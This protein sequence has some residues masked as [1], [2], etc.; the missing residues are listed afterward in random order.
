M[1]GCFRGLLADSGLVFNL[2]SA[3][4]IAAGVQ[5]P[6]EDPA[7]IEVV[8]WVRVL[9][10]LK[11]GQNTLV[12]PLSAW[13]RMSGMMRIP[14]NG[15]MPL[16]LAGHSLTGAFP[17]RTEIGTSSFDCRTAGFFSPA[18]SQN[19]TTVQSDSKSSPTTGPAA[20]QTPDG[21]EQSQQPSTMGGTSP[22][23]SSPGHSSSWLSGTS[24]AVTGITP[25]RMGSGCQ[26]NQ[27]VVQSSKPCDYIDI[28]AQD[29]GRTPRSCRTTASTSHLGHHTPRTTELD[30]SPPEHLH[31][32]PPHKSTQ[33]AERDLLDWDL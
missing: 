30:T 23:A 12:E 29:R 16:P 13:T 28:S 22:R 3:G 27:S 2:S 8:L 20:S 24:P 31:F 15:P 1:G 32:S 26:V 9:S 19:T 6:S 21:G 14:A 7:K 5:A 4:V 17:P 18:D 10:G 11:E 33:R 25:L